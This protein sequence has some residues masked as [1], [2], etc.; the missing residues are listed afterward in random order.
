M[1]TGITSDSEI[2]STEK[3][4]TQFLLHQM[5]NCTKHF[6]I[7]GGECPISLGRRRNQPSYLIE[8]LSGVLVILRQSYITIS[9][10]SYFSVQAMSGHEET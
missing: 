7:H 2:V 1:Q 6:K 4:W 9:N 8:L 10:T 5:L 3:I